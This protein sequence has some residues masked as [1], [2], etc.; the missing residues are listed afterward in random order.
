[1]KRLLKLLVL[2]ISIMCFSIGATA[3]TDGI[4]FAD[5]NNYAITLSFSG[6]TANCGLTIDG[7]AGTTFL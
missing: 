2:G 6:S 4:Y 3:A 1:M 7:A 5:V